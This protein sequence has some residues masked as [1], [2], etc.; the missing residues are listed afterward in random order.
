MY[1][2][3]ALPWGNFPVVVQTMT[4]TDTRDTEGSV[5]QCERII[6]AGTDLIRSP[7]RSP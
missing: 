2:W 3:G 7:H 1:L 6:A 5:A 4:N